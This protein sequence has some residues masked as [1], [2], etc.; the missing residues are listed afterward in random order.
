MHP[1]QEV[2]AEPSQITGPSSAPTGAPSD[3]VVTPDRIFQIASGFMAAKHLFVANEV[4][5]FAALTKGRRR[6]DELAAGTGVAQ[7][8]LRILADAMVALGLLDRTP[9]RA[10]CPSSS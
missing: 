1:G 4:G 9:D 6:L 3:E 5:I 7:H 2:P 8:R 10:R